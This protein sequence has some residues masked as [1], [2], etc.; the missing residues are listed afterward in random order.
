MKILDKTTKDG[1][2]VMGRRLKKQGSVMYI[3]TE[4]GSNQFIPLV[5][6]SNN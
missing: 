3:E 4:K 1:G 5:T 6:K 2:S